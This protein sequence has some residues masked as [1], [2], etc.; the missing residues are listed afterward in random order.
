MTPVEIRSLYVET[1]TKAKLASTTFVASDGFLSTAIRSNEE[2][3]QVALDALAEVGLLPI[4]ADYR[5][6]YEPD[7]TPLGYTERQLLTDW[8]RMPQRPPCQ[9]GPDMCM[10]PTADFPAPGCARDSTVLKAFYDTGRI[11]E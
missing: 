9:C 5:S 8:K 1:L 6:A 10:Q 7:G 11:A 2:A 3:V 4:Y